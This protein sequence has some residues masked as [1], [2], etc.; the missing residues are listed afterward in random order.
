LYKIKFIFYSLQAALNQLTKNLSIELDARGILV[1][2]IHP[3]RVR[4]DMGGPNAEI[5]LYDSIRGIIKVLM[6]LNEE[7]AG[8]LYSYTGRVIPW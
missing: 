2:G 8:N 1:T 6:G 4:T 7:S 5:G 3:G